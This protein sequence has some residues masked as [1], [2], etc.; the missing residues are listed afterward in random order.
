VKFTQLLFQSL[1]VTTC[2]F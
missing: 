1:G 2:L